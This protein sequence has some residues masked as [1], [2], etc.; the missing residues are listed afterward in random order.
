MQCAPMNSLV[1]LAGLD[2]FISHV[3]TG[4]R[5]VFLRHLSTVFNSNVH[6]PNGFL[7]FVLLGVASEGVK[8]DLEKFL[9]MPQR[10]QRRYKILLSEQQ[11]IRQVLEEHFPAGTPSATLDK[12]AEL[13]A[14]AGVPYHVLKWH[15]ASAA[16]KREGAAPGTGSSMEPS[17]DTMKDEVKQLIRSCKE[18]RGRLDQSSEAQRERLYS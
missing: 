18:E 8:G 2:M 12:L 7:I 1:V 4:E 13:A 11:R 17:A 3:P 15:F 14:E 6:D 16:E 9:L 5:N 10:C